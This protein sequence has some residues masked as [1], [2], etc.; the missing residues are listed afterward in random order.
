MTVL[1][2]R[3]CMERTRVDEAK[4]ERNYLQDAETH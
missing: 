1:D 2:G 4:K 3:K